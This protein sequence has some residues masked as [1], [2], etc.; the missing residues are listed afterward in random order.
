MEEILKQG[1]AFITAS[2]LG[3]SLVII[4]IGIHIVRELKQ[5]KE[6]LS[7]SNNNYDKGN[8]NES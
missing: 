7:S 5:I 3:V 4:G 2:I 8:K 6:N 1:F